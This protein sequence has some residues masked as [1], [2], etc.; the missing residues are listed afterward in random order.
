ML[1]T[2]SRMSMEQQAKVDFG[3]AIS[4]IRPH[5]AELAEGPPA[6]D[7]ITEATLRFGTCELRM[8]RAERL[9]ALGLAEAEA[10]ALAEAALSDNERG[11]AAL[12][13]VQPFADALTGQL[14]YDEILSRWRDASREIRVEWRDQVSQ[15]DVA[16]DDAQHLVRI[17]D[18]CCDAIDEEGLR[19]LGRYL[20]RRVEELGELRRSDD[21]GTR[22]GSVP[23]HKIAAA[24]IILGMT[25]YAVWVLLMSGAPWWDF[26]LLALIACIMMLIVAIGC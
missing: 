9:R 2:P 3:I 7:A 17:M 12:S 1:N 5:I 11:L 20:S 14:S 18:E 13:G 22:A 4:Q 23:W 15:L 24:A 19:G 16:A 25:A 6:L 8:R 26:Y 10:V 21:R